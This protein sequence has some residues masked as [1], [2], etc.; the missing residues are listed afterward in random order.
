M[1]GL[2]DFDEP[3]FWLKISP[4]AD[5]I[6]RVSPFCFSHPVDS[7]Q[8]EM[9]L[10]PKTLEL[11]AA[12]GVEQDAQRAFVTWKCLTYTEIALLATEEKDVKTDICE[13]MKAM[14]PAVESAKTM[15]GLVSRSRHVE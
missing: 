10:C 15:I 9:A 1:D 5:R 11:A 6:A 12:A 8:T 3:P 4:A 2:P 7:A 13:P 14:S